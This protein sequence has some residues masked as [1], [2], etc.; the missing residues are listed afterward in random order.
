M[1]TFPSE[2]KLKI[3]VS[4]GPKRIELI[5]VSCAGHPVICRPAAMS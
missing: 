4:S 2:P 1:I 5:A 3:L